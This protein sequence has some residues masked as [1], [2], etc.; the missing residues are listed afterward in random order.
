VDVRMRQASARRWPTVRSSSLPLR[1]RRAASIP[2]VR[3]REP[4]AAVADMRV[5]AAVELGRDGELR[6]SRR[7]PSASAR[8]P[9]NLARPAGQQPSTRTSSAD[10]RLLQLWRTPAASPTRDAAAASTPTFANIRSASLWTAASPLSSIPAPTADSGLPGRSWALP[11][12]ARLRFGRRRPPA[13]S[14]A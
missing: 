10:R 5:R 13:R 1:P 2:C 9:A 7:L 14:P 6:K 3:R 11:T 4:A 8:P 12:P